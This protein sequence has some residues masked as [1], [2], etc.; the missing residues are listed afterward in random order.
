MG[1]T[2]V[3][4]AADMAHLPDPS[5]FQ[6]E[7]WDK[8]A[9]AK[10]PHVVLLAVSIS[11][12]NHGS[13]LGLVTESMHATVVYSDVIPVRSPGTTSRQPGTLVRLRRPFH[14]DHYRTDKTITYE[15]MH[16]AITNEALLKTTKVICK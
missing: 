1:L 6:E 2:G 16:K 12:R 13:R 15:Y 7:D 3:T 10:G 9:M 5:F 8:D 11:S 14:L 4:R